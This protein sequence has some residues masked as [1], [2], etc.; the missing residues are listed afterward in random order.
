MYNDTIK[1]ANKIITDKDLEEIFFKMHE[2]IQKYDKIF[3][4]E[5]RQNQIYEDNYQNW[6]LKNFERNLKFTIN[7]YDDTT[8]SFENYYSF[9]SI[10]NSRI[11]E[12]KD[13]YV[14]YS[15]SYFVQHPNI[16]TEYYHQ[17]II[18][19]IY[20]EEMSIN[21]NLSNQDR[22]MEEVYN[23]IKTKIL[24]APQ[25][26][27]NIIKKKVSIIN[28]V[29]LSIGLMPSLVLCTLLL[30][31][32]EVRTICAK[33]YVVYPICSILLGFII[34]G[35]ISGSKLDRLYKPIVPEKKYDGYDSINYK[36]IYKDDI[37]KYINTSEILIG[38]NV[39]NLK[40]RIE[41]KKLYEKHKKNISYKLLT[42]LI[43]SLIVL[44]LSGI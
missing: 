17:E 40:S 16:K 19:N 43:L 6:S 22:K 27:D 26:Y 44:F 18:M 33:G 15:Y 5:I 8:I 30:F 32:P 11:D 34:G 23:L 21:V 42:V 41:I 29:E 39:N 37:N 10:F 25:K 7:F 1:V 31:V 38:K 24:N 35:T 20:E 36:S 2:Y 28:I 14:W 3:K 9:I 4:S 12:V 13:I